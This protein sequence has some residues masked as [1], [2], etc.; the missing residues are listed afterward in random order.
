M[1]IKFRYLLS[2]KHTMTY[3]NKI[4]IIDINQFEIT[5]VFVNFF[6]AKPKKKCFQIVASKSAN[7]VEIDN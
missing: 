3:F 4:I 1:V 6:I 2:L 5:I 7:N